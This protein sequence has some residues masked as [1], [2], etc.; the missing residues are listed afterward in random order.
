M[1]IGFAVVLMTLVAALAF[2]MVTLFTTNLNL[3]Q[4]ANNGAV[5]LDEAE[6]GLN[7]VLLNLA[8]DPDYGTHGESFRRTINTSFDATQCY[9]EVS[10]DNA[11]SAIPFSIN[12][13]SGSATGFAGRA[14]EAECVHVI[15]TGYCRGQYRT[16][17]AVVRQPPFNYALASAGPIRSSNPLRVEGIDSR[18]AYAQG[19]SEPLPGH[20][21]SN[22]SEGIVIQPTAGL[23]SY[24]SGQAR[25]AG[26]VVM[27]PDATVLLG[28]RADSAPLDLP[29]IDVASFDPMG[30]DGLQV[31]T[32]STSDLTELTSTYRAE[33]ATNFTGPVNFGSGLLY[34]TGAV[35]FEQGVAGSG[36]IIADGDVTIRGVGSQFSGTDTVAILASGKVTIEGDPNQAVNA[37]ANANFINGL[38]YGDRGVDLSNITVA[39]IVLTRDSSSTTQLTNTNVMY[40]SDAAELRIPLAPLVESGGTELPPIFY[41][42]VN[43]DGSFSP[44]DPA[45]DSTSAGTLYVGLPPGLNQE[46]QNSVWSNQISDPPGAQ[47]MQDYIGTFIN[48]N[49]NSVQPGQLASSGG[50]DMSMATPEHSQMSDWVSRGTLPDQATWMPVL[51]AM[52]SSAPPVAVSQWE[53]TRPASTFV[54]DLNNFLPR[55]A[56][57][58]VTGACIHNRHL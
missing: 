41:G 2:A 8:A 53:I 6:A 18:S 39:G 26:P 42:K 44:I 35:T 37:N 23:S 14:V 33:Q 21:A 9:H 25:A 15:S 29:S 24:I 36:A 58:R 10:F 11:Q 43:A 38:V 28:T 1:S 56:T 55:S 22:A 5:A 31:I 51:Q 34:V 47:T 49:P 45:S 16:L 13:R 12:A 40:V 48:N 54:L 52:L 46:S 30:S 32:T 19:T 20:I 27:D 3:M 7:Q 50:Y 4:A 17:E 57:L